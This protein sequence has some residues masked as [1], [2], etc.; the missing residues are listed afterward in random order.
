MVSHDST[1]SP[2]P[3]RRNENCEIPALSIGHLLQDL[4]ADYNFLM[5]QMRHFVCPGIESRPLKPSPP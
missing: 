4:R 3:P 5:A 2:I 1:K